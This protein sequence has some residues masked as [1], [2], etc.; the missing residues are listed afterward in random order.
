M[1]ADRLPRIAGVSPSKVKALTPRSPA[2]LSSS[3]SATWSWASALVGN[4]YSALA[5]SCIAALTT[6]RV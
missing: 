6:G 1:Q 5:L 3:S 4:R 2:R